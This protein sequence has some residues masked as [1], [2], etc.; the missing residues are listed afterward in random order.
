M[1]AGAEEDL[2]QSERL[3]GQLA[4]PKAFHDQKSPAKRG[5]WA[6]KRT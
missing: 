4:T 2:S 6:P 3:E 1:R 5:L